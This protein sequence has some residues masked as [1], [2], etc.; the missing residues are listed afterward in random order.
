MAKKATTTTSVSKYK[1]SAK[2]T[3]KDEGKGIDKSELEKIFEPFYRTDKS[4]NKKIQGY[5]L[6]L[7]LVKK[8]LDGHGFQF[9]IK[10]EPGAGS[11]F[12]IH[13]HVVR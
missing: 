10:S 7:S 4:R 1:D 5:G 13:F 2:I 12:V 11:E 8:I 6:G 3:V 9:E